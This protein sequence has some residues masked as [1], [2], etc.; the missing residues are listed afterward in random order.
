MQEPAATNSIYNLM[1][2]SMARAQLEL[3]RNNSMER[4]VHIRHL[5]HKKTVPDLPMLLVKGN[6]IT[7]HL[8]LKVHNSTS[9]IPHLRLSMPPKLLESLGRIHS[10]IRRPP[11]NMLKELRWADILSSNTHLRLRHPNHG[12]ELRSHL[13]RAPSNTTHRRQLP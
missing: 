1:K 12:M 2:A 6:S 13:D 3:L 9:S 8:R 4:L 11:L 7:H 5:L 10:I